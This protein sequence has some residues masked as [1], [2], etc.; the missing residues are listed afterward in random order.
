VGLLRTK[1]KD[2]VQGT[3]QVVAS[4][5]P[6]HNT[7]YSPLEMTLVVQ[8]DGIAPTSV[9]HKQKAARTNKFPV[10]G[11][12]IPVEIDRRDPTRV[13]VLWDQIPTRDEQ[14]RAQGDA[15]AA[16]MRGQRPEPG[17]AGD[18]AGAP[19]QVA[20]I[21]EHLQRAFPGATVNVQG[22]AA[23]TPAGGGD[24][25]VGRLERLAKLRDAGALT[26]EEFEREKARILSGP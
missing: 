9:R 24:D 6:P 15:L 10:P 4:S 14:A 8:A 16:T 3:A 18:G 13:R 5:R 12:V 26:P 1:L 17:G 20:G 22:G 21:V 25:R 2:P 19:E 7:L 23:A 11:Q